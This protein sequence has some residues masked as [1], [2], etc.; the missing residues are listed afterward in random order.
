MDI[1]QQINDAF[2]LQ[3]KYKYQMRNT[4]ISYR[5]DKLKKIKALLVEQTYE[6]AQA[7]E[8]DFRKSTMEVKLTEILPLISMIN[9]L[10]KK[11]PKWSK[12]KKVKTPLLYKGTKSWIRYEGK[13]NCLV[14]SPW[15]YPFQLSLYPL[16]TAF[17][18]GNTVICKPSEF[19]PNTNKIIVDLVSK[20]F[21]PSEVQFI[22][23]DSSVS[24]ALLDKPFDHIFFTGSTQVGKIVMEKAAKHLA[25]VGLEL[26]GKSPT[27]VDS[28][29]NIGEVAQKVV[30]GKFMNAG[31][32]CVAPDYLLINSGDLEELIDKLKHNIQKLYGN[33]ED[34]VE[35][36]D[37]NQI[38]THRHAQRLND[39]LTD[40]V[41]KGATI[42]Y[43]GKYFPEHKILGP[44]ILINVTKDMRLMQEEIFGPILPII[45][46]N[47]IDEKIEFINTFD[48]ALAKYI[49]S[50]NP[51]NIQKLIDHTSNGGVTINECMMAVAH[52]WLPFGG[53]GKSGIGRYHGELGFHEF[54]NIRPIM[55]RKYDLGTSYFYPPY[56]DQ[57]NS[58]LYSLM[59][60]FTNWF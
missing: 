29:V 32:T 17:A 40:A 59:K 5:V 27:V 31:Q 43:G 8:K 48:N 46:L 60:K 42:V 7:I 44:T 28:G 49:F 18:A 21:T 38:V 47:S 11:L 52:P 24:S 6:I 9:V 55:E 50:N 22:E 36:K 57:K 12:V 41:E 56:S 23:G 1:N 13:G 45:T 58:I 35:I 10:E 15:N 39:L 3:Q 26:G 33:K 25:S 20:V 34:W 51:K 54:S 19:T 37:F 30:W 2:E 4:S 14:I 16:L 53:A